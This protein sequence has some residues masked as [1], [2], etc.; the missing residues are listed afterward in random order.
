MTGAIATVDDGAVTVALETDQTVKALGR[1]TDRSG[2]RCAPHFVAVLASSGTDRATSPLQSTRGCLLGEQ[3]GPEA[4]I[5][6]LL[7]N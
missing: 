4:L 6:A 7:G 1:S 5:E 2:P 3:Y